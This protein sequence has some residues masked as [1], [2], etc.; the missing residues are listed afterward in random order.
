MRNAFGRVFGRGAAAAGVVI[1]I[2]VAIAVVIIVSSDEGGEEIE[3]VRPIEPTIE[4]IATDSER[5]IGETVTVTGD[6]GERLDTGGAFTLAGDPAL[7]VVVVVPTGVRGDPSF[8][9]GETLEVTGVVT[10]FD[11][12]D[13]PTIVDSDL[14]PEDFEGYRNLALV[15]ATDITRTTSAE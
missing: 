6:V 5:Y 1:A 12:P 7:N 13:L 2:V 3:A 14:A 4:D 8:T 10:G 11:E 15:A 9:P